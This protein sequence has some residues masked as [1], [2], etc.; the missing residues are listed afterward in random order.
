VRDKR[1]RGG[2]EMMCRSRHRRSIHA[3]KILVSR[4]LRIDR[5]RALRIFRM[6]RR[7]GRRE[8][9]VA[10]GRA[11]VGS[12]R[13]LHVCTFRARVASCQ[14]RGT[15]DKDKSETILANPR[16]VTIHLAW[17]RPYSK[18]AWTSSAPRSSSWTSS[19]AMFNLVT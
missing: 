7:L 8:E 17:I 18:R 16:A 2:G 19:S 12:G 3:V 10:P 4:C 5:R 1:G 15:M 11:H 6:G 9:V 13:S 14:S